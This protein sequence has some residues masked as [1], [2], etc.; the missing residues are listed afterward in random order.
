MCYRKVLVREKGKWSSFNIINYNKAILSPDLVINLI[1]EDKFNYGRYDW[2]REVQMKEEKLYAWPNK[3]KLLAVL[4]RVAWIL[5]RKIDDTYL[6]LLIWLIQTL[7]R[8]PNG[9]TCPFSGG[10]DCCRYQNPHQQNGKGL[11]VTIVSG[12]HSCHCK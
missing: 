12:S 2:K 8:K 3:M 11:F 9:K 10:H 1:I 6:C 7:Q 5:L 4:T